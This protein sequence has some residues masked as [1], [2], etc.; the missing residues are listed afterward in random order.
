MAQNYYNYVYFFQNHEELC[1]ISA[2]A[3]LLVAW[4]SNTDDETTFWKQQHSIF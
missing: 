4:W 1:S 3:E 2:T